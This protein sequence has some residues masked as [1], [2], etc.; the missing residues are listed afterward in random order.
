MSTLSIYDARKLHLCQEDPLFS[1]L[2]LMYIC[3]YDIEESVA[4][5]AAALL[6]LSHSEQDILDAVDTAEKE[7]NNDN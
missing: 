4:R 2:Y 3:H 7:L 6:P 1:V 5:R